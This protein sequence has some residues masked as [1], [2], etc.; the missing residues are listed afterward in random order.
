MEK[1][2][3]SQPEYLSKAA[4]YCALVEHCEAEVREK[5]YQWSCPECW[6][7]DIIDYLY[8]QNFLN[9]ERYCRAFVHDKVAYQA[10]GRVKIRAALMARHLPT[11]LIDTALKNLDKAEYDRQLVHLIEKKQSPDRDKLLR[12]LLQ[13]GFT[14]DEIEQQ[15]QP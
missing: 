3:L 8:D 11:A 1:T 12:F 10:W 14:Y 13:R 15:L 4:R 2:V 9:D 6:H 5:L 7:D